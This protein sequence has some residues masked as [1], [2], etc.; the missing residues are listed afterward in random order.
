MPMRRKSVLGRD[1]ANGGEAAHDQRTSAAHGCVLREVQPTRRS[2][3]W[4]LGRMTQ[5]ESLPLHCPKC[6]GAIEV[7]YEPGEVQRAR[8]VCPYCHE[9]REFEAPG[10]IV[11]VAMRQT[12]QGPETKH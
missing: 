3:A 6:G 7:A 5:S 11:A 12:G 1:R 2:E 4:S 8:F 9:P 10:K